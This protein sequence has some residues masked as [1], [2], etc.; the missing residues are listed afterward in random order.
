MARRFAAVVIAVE[1]KKGVGGEYDIDS[2]HTLRKPM[3]VSEI[4]N[5]EFDPAC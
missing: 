4:A 3:Q 5:P 2:S 1:V